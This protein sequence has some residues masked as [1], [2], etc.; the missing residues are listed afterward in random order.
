[1]TCRNLDNM[2]A[3]VPFH[4]MSASRL[5]VR[6]RQAAGQQQVPSARRVLSL[7]ALEISLWEVATLH[8]LGR[9]RLVETLG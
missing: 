3:V 2:F 8:G 7:V 1:M 5:N 9:L 4:T 6:R